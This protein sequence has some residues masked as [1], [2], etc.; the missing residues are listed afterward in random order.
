MRWP[1][2]NDAETEERAQ[3]VLAFIT[4]LQ[5]DATVRE[6]AGALSISE[7]DAAATTAKLEQ[8]RR[9]IRRIGLTPDDRTVA[10]GLPDD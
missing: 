7:Q 9:V 8:Q 3:A 6:I 1:P 2:M 4:R 5:R 10:F